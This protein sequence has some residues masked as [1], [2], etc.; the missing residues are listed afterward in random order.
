M[1]FEIPVSKP[2]ASG[3]ETERKRKRNGTDVRR[4]G[5]GVKRS[6]L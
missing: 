2:G 5:D 1:D 4:K 6:F 3:F